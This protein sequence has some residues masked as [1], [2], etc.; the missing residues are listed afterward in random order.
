MMA[1][2]DR[3]AKAEQLEIMRERIKQ[4]VDAMAQWSAYVDTAVA[5]AKMSLEE[6]RKILAKA[7]V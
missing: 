6:L 4:E 2:Y 3:Q 7:K 1:H 5:K